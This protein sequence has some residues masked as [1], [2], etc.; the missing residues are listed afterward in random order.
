LPKTQNRL[1]IGLLRSELNH[2]K[3]KLNSTLVCKALL[4]LTIFSSN[5]ST[6]IAQ[7]IA[8]AMKYENVV[9]ISGTA[10]SVDAVYKFPSVT[11]GVD[12]FI[13]IKELNGGATLT[14]IDDNTYGYSAAWQPVVKTPNVQGASESYVGFKIEFKDSSDGKSHK[15]DCAQLSFIDVDGDN[16]HV[17]EFVAAKQYDSYTVSNLSI[18][19]L[20]VIDGNLLKA[21]GTFQN[22]TGLD[23]SSY[24]TN[25]NYRYSNKDKIEEVRVGNITDA[26]FTV[27]DRYSCGYFKEMSMPFLLVLPVK[28]LSFNAVVVE[29]KSVDLKWM[30]E[31][32]INNGHYEIER[33]LD[34]NNFKT[35][36]LVLDGF[37]INGS[38]KSYEFMDNSTDI[39]G[40]SIVYYRLKQVDVDNKVSF[41]KVLP[42]KFQA[43]G[44]V[45]MQVSPNPFVEN[46]T[47]RFNSS[48]KGIAEIRLISASGQ[49]ML[50]KQSIISKGYNNIQLDGLSNL[51]NGMYVARLVM[52]GV[53]IDNQKIIKN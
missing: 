28:L 13:T 11:P 3:M 35:I 43:K 37:K 34:M 32:E 53:V 50:S 26:S 15:Y 17:K 48:E 45:V 19:S 29:N 31:Q 49:T 38:V 2:K 5:L 21:T 52:N 20:S 16:Q 25:I 23:T 51:N 40:K 18:L 1:I 44:A 41:S 30:T 47:V 7:C 9:L 4:A 24:V 6:A 42:V 27:Q 46:L 22:F 8:P 36:G 10:G 39:Q 12:A 14:S 33:S